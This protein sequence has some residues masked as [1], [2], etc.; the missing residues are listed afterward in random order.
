MCVGRGFSR[1]IGL[2]K[3]AYEGEPHRANDSVAAAFRRA[4]SGYAF[5]RLVL[6]AEHI[7]LAQTKT[8]RRPEGRRYKGLTEMRRVRIRGPKSLA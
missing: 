7:A 6:S 5:E 3:N 4:N 1:D 2:D 8:K